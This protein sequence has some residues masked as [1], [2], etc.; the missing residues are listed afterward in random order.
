MRGLALAALCG[1]LALGLAACGDSR[2]E[3][4]NSAATNEAGNMAASGEGS[5]TASAGATASA[6]PEG[7]RIV[8]EN[9]VTY[10]VDS[11]GTRVQLGPNDSR[12]VVTE[13]VRYRVDPDGTR[14]RIDTRGTAV[15]IGDS[16]ITDNAPN[17]RSDVETPDET[18]RD[19]AEDTV[20][21]VGDAVPD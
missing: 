4:N 20:E 9:G 8:E 11:A 6:W 16:V 17:G 12:I 10:R 2:D 1:P 13:G 3:A 7:A 5:G 14:V 15:R 18:V 21:A 19:A